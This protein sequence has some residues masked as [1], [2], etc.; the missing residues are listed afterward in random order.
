MQLAPMLLPKTAPGKHFKGAIVQRTDSACCLQ[1]LIYELTCMEKRTPMH[2][3]TCTTK[4]KQNYRMNDTTWGTLAPLAQG[5]P[6]AC[7][8]TRTGVATNTNASQLTQGRAFTRTATHGLQAK[9]L[10]HPARH[11]GD[12]ACMGDGPYALSSSS[13]SALKAQLAALPACT[14][15]HSPGCVRLGSQKQWS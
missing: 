11:R 15:A 6:H 3:I 1:Q 13:S 12:D 7:T 5:Q 2:C 10:P 4:R 9:N 8:R 14:D